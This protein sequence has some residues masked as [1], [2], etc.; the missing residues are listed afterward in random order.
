MGRNYIP[1]T[2]LQW[3]TGWVNCIA[4]FTTHVINYTCW[5]YGYGN[6][7]VYMA[8]CS[9]STVNSPHKWPVTRKMFPFD[10][11]IMVCSFYYSWN[12]ILGNWSAFVEYETGALQKKRVCH[13]FILTKIF[14]WISNMSLTVPL[15]TLSIR[16]LLQTCSKNTMQCI[17][18]SLW[19]L[20]RTRMSVNYKIDVISELHGLP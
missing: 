8:K 6:D 14:L 3:C 17:V 15:C 5:D 4:H 9:R 1:I 16:K 7:S 12:V 10:D 19:I 18:L 2:K 11:V 13:L 20:I